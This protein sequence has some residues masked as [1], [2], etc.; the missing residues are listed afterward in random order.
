MSELFQTDDSGTEAR[1]RRDFLE[2]LVEDGVETETLMNVRS[3][4]A[5]EPAEPTVSAGEDYAA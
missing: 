3:A 1:A 4:E 5:D 2:G